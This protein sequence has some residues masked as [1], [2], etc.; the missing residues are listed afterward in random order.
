[1]SQTICNCWSMWLN[2]NFFQLHIS[3]LQYSNLQSVITKSF[4]STATIFIYNNM[5]GLCLIKNT[6]GKCMTLL[7]IIYVYLLLFFW[8][9]VSLKTMGKCLLNYLLTI[10]AL[11]KHRPPPSIIVIPMQQCSPIFIS[12]THSIVEWYINLPH[13]C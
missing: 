11:W 3:L 7:Y 13:W 8:E 10:K 12:Y 6:L 9:L 5:M 1:M 2:N 4:S